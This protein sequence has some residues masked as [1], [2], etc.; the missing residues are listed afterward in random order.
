MGAPGM[1]ETLLSLPWYYRYIFFRLSQAQNAALKFAAKGLS[2]PPPGVLDLFDASAVE[3][4][5]ESVGSANQRAD[6]EFEAMFKTL[7]KR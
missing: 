5:V 7:E 1:G 4:Y 6:E 2:L 3:T